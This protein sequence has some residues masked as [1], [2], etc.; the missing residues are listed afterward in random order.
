MN[1]RNNT[2]TRGAVGSIVVSHFQDT[3]FDAELGLLSVFHFVPMSI[4]IFSFLQPPKHI[5]IEEDYLC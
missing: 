4:W 3:Q 5:N 1:S 2:S